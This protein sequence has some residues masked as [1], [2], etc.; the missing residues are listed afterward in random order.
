MK[1]P[2]GPE[3]ERSEEQ[4]RPGGHPPKCQERNGTI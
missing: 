2:P 4:L 1:V 3:G